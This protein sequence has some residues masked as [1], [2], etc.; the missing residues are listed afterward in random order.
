MNNNT[1]NTIKD[2]K[3]DFVSNTFGTTLTEVFLAV[4]LPLFT[5]TIH[6]LLF[7]DKRWRQPFNFINQQMYFVLPILLGMTVL[8]DYLLLIDCALLCLLV[9]ILLYRTNFA[10]GS[11][12][13]CFTKCPSDGDTGFISNY[14]AIMQIMTGFCI[15]AV[16]FD[17]FPRRFAKA[18]VFGIGCMDL[19]VGAFVLSM[20]LTSPPAKGRQRVVFN[21]VLQTISSSLILIILGCARTFTVKM[22]NYQEHVTEYGAHWN[23]FLTLALVRIVGVCLQYLLPWCRSQLGYFLLSVL[24]MTSYQFMLSKGN[25][26]H[27]FQ[28]GFHGDDSRS[29]FLD[30]NREGLLSSYGF[31]SVYFF[32][33]FLGVQLF[34]LHLTPFNK[35]CWL[36]S[37]FT[38]SICVLQ[39]C[40]YYVTPISR[41]M[42]NASY[43]FV[44]IAVNLLILGCLLC[45]Q[46]AIKAIN[47]LKKKDDKN[48]PHSNS[49]STLH[50]TISR[51]QLFYFLLA[52][53][54]T[55]IVNKSVNTL[56]VSRLE[57][58]FILGIYM[59]VLNSAI[60]IIDRY[61]NKYFNN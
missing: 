46:I 33:M 53:V 52:N 24:L 49:V 42:V 50:G 6:C 35:I 25:V 60:F 26:Q 30:A 40:I 12:L 55:G 29:N 44:Q 9:L 51:N 56:Y 21:Y 41:Q 47:L 59:M 37:W 58:F 43:Y 39:L 23:F 5:C 16:D 20:G 10:I 48:S 54:L 18:E 28:H 17:I 22:T 45:S 38:A 4:V 19:G 31:L 3:V 15:L 36:A 14:K 11:F 2:E 32:G 13:Q 1:T 61:L 7:Q 57:S 8:S 27:I 34:K